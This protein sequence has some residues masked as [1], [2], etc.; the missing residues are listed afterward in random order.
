MTV[1]ITFY[2]DSRMPYKMESKGKAYYLAYVI[3]QEHSKLLQMQ[4]A[5]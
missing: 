4:E 3:K 5:E 2:A 1:M